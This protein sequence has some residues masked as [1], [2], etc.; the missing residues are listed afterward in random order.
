MKTH[1]IWNDLHRPLILLQPRRGRD[2]CATKAISSRPRHRTVIPDW[3]K[4]VKFDEK[5]EAIAFGKSIFCYK[6]KL[7]TND[8]FFAQM[9]MENVIL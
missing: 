9:L 6:K 2:L 8:S 4:H 1:N 3:P 5:E 7:L